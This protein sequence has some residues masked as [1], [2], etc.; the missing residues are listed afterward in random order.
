MIFHADSQ[1]LSPTPVP[2]SQKVGS[3]IPHLNALDLSVFPNMSR[4]HSKLA[5]TKN[6]QIWAGCYAG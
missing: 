4:R 5:T 6:Q 1:F 2:T 3:Q